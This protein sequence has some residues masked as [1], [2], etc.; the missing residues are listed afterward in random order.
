MTENYTV[1]I[2]EDA[3]NDLRGIYSYIANELLVPD[4]AMMQVER[5]RKQVKA[6]SFLPAR[7][8]L[9]DWEPWKSMGMHQLP[10]DNYIVF[11]IVDN[12]AFTVTV[13]RVFYC[14]RDIEGII[15]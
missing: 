5:I 9:V 15:N 7:F 2:S 3:L 8:A 11:Y 14:G 13:V 6:L 12:K 4:T 1:S 10:V